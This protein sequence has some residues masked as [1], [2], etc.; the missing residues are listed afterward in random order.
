MICAGYG[1]GRDACHG[2][3]GGPLVCNGNGGKAVLTGVVSHGEDC[4]IGGE[5]GVYGRVTEVLPWIKDHMVS[6]LFLY[7]N[8]SFIELL[9]VN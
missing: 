4:G 8:F 5:P 9:K 2:D 6:V 7:Q 3:S 1:L